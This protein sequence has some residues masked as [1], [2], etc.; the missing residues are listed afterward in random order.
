MAYSYIR[1]LYLRGEVIA[2]QIALAVNV[3]V[4]RL[5]LCEELIGE[6]DGHFIEH[7]GVVILIPGAEVI[8][9]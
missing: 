6:F 2:I 7:R 1:R 5:E 3:Q 4:R 9:F 8:D